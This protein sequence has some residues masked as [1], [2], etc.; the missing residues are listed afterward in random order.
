MLVGGAGPGIGVPVRGE[1]GVDGSRAGSLQVNKFEH[2]H[3]CGVVTW[4]ALLR[5]QND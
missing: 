1:G 3:R 2:V 4:S 5:G